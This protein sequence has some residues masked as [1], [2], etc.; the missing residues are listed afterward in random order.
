MAPR[1]SAA[2]SARPAEPQ[3]LPWAWLS[4]D[5]GPGIWRES[6]WSHK[7]KKT[8]DIVFLKRK[9][10]ERDK[11]KAIWAP[12]T[13]SPAL[14]FNRKHQTSYLR[15]HSNP[16]A[17]KGQLRTHPDQ[18]QALPACTA[19]RPMRQ[20]GVWAAGSRG[21]RSQE[22]WSADTT[23]AAAAEGLW[24][25]KA[26]HVGTCHGALGV[27]LSQHFVLQHRGAFGGY[28]AGE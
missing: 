12:L 14:F 11:K 9:K 21:W 24:E 28:R 1:V 25:D 27:C 5:R 10:G 2:P 18:S 17:W 16:G 6:F 8:L 15:Q 13:S 4:T 3:L 7:S 20:Q 23:S 22:H 26:E 19:P